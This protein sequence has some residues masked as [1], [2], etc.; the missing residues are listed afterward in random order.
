MVSCCA[1]SV[2]LCLVWSGLALLS[3]RR[4]PHDGPLNPS[5]QNVIAYDCIIITPPS[6]ITIA[7]IDEEPLYGLFYSFLDLG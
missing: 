6:I 3:P 1:N 7:N 2:K 4:V 5:G